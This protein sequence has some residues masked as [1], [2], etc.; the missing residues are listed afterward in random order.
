MQ[1]K[2]SYLQWFKDNVTH[3][4][5]EPSLHDEIDERAAEDEFE[6][7]LNDIDMMEDFRD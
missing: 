3:V 7:G 2:P 1:Y 6:A 5:I 4:L